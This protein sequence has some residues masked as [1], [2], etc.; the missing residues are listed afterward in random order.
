M[1]E[2]GSSFQ[3]EFRDFAVKGCA[4]DLSQGAIVGPA[5]DVIVSSFVDALSL[6]SPKS[7]SPVRCLE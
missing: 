3:Q 7:T 2:R 6:S 4:V 1:R 5:F